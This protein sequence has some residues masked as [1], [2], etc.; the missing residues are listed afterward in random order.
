VVRLVRRR[1]WWLVAIGAAHVVLLWSGDI[2]AAYGVLAVALGG[3]VVTG[4]T[5]SLATTAVV[6]SVLG[7]GLGAF[8]AYSP[9]GTA[10]FP[11]VAVCVGSAR[12][13]ATWDSRC[14]S[15]RCCRPGRWAW[16]AA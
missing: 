5:V 8:S 12:C 3:M 15:S 13:R 6:G 14:C 16:A 4:T 7:T 2:V 1:G 9:P 10:P 11:S